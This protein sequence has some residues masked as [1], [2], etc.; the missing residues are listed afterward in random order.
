MIRTI[1]STYIYQRG[2]VVKVLIDGEVEIHRI[3]F[4]MMSETMDILNQRGYIHEIWYT[5]FGGA[6]FEHSQVIE[7]VGISVFT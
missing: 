6:R 1:G 3:D 5:A 7:Q 4:H 2:D